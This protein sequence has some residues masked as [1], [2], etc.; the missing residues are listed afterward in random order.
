MWRKYI[1][2]PRTFKD[3]YS[4]EKGN[5]QDHRIHQYNDPPRQIT[6]VM[7]I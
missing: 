4:K 5:I 2:K 3:Q 1:L 6:Q 7:N